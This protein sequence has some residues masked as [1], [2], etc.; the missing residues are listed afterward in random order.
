MIMMKKRCIQVVPAAMAVMVLL[1]A[2]AGTPAKTAAE[3]G[4]SLDE[5]I[6][7]IARGLEDGLPA[8]TRVAVV[9]LESPSAY[10]SDYVL[11]ELQGVLVSNQRL[12]VVERAK[13]ELLRN[14][15]Q[16]QM[17]GEVDGETAVNMGKW[18]GAQFVVA[19][20]LA[21]LNGRYRF[22]FN[23]TDVETAAQKVSPAA[24]VRRDNDIAALLPAGT[25][26]A[27]VS[28]KA[29]PAL[30]TAYFNAGFA[31]YEAKRYTEAA[32]DFT[33]ALAVKK[34]DEA[35]LRYRAYSYYYLKDY[36]RSITDM[37][38]LI[39]MNPGNAGRY[40]HSRSAAYGKKGDMDRAIAD[41]NE[42]LRLNPDEAGAYSNRGNAYDGKGEYDR[43]IADF[44]EAIRLNPNS[45]DAY[46]NRGMAYEH[47]REYDKAIADHTQAIRINPR[48]AVAYYN[49]GNAY[50]RK[51]EYNG[52]LADYNEALRHNPDLPEAYVN[53]G[54]V[55]IL[56][57]E[58]DKAIADCTLAI[59]HNPDLP[60][61]YAFRG[62][63]YADKGEPDRAIADYTQAIRLNPNYVDAYDDRGDAYVMKED[64]ARARADWEKVLQLNPNHTYARR[65]LE[66][67]R[68]DGH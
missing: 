17:S 43:A 15:A 12:V 21:D 55:Y 6:A 49:R 44:N 28:D 16:F 48:N 9:N 61:A 59:R 40:Y 32:A 11:Q 37:S 1:S 62:V 57:G 13:L 2:C 54:L 41:C 5:G 25:A 33:L 8:G 68:R 46:S 27:Q 66:Q 4:L 36:D 3:D 31:H 45:T 30:M 10:F 42:V 58:Y 51:G 29:D 26:L 52:A 60:G 67:L 56:K 23:A 35:S 20:N 39:E 65:S 64:Y 53:R 63:A 22:R 24:T 14:E 7:Q 34:D 19:G 38:R 47:K 18:L 50:Y